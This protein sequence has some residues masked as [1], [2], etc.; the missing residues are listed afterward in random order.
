M[1]NP[2]NPCLTLKLIDEKPIVKTRQIPRAP[3]LRIVRLYRDAS[4]ALNPAG[5]VKKAKTVKTVVLAT[6]VNSQ[7]LTV[8]TG[9]I[10]TAYLYCVSRVTRIYSFKVNQLQQSAFWACYADD[11]CIHLLIFVSALWRMT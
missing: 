6:A 8:K 9:Q 1:M 3:K 4:E 5:P 2:R 7:A 10:E 11:Q